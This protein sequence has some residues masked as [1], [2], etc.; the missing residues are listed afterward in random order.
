MADWL[1]LRLAA[2]RRPRRRAGS[3][4]MRAATPFP[5]RRAAR[6]RRRPAR[7]AGRHV[8]VLVPG[9]DVLLAEPEVPVKA[10]TKLQQVVPYA[11]EEQLA[12]RHRRPAL[13]HRQARRRIPSTTPV[14]VVAHSLMDEWLDHAQGGRPRSGVDVRGQ[15][16]AA[17]E[18]GSRRR[19]ARDDVVVVRPPTGATISMPADALAEALELARPERRMPASRPAAA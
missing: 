16:S 5:R 8:C 13:R 9:T 18:S 19:A 17:R 14:A 10:G 11:L 12:R 4:R 3:S 7:A 15:R 6:W 2:H 1:L